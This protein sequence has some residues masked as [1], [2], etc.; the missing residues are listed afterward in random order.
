MSVSLKKVFA[1]DL[2]DDSDHLIYI[3]DWNV[4]LTQLLDTSSYLHD[5]YIK[6][7]E[8]V[9]EIMTE[10]ERTDV[11]RI[12]NADK[13]EYTW[14]K[15]QRKNRTL[16][17]LD[18]LLVSQNVISEINENK[19]TPSRK[20]NDHCPLTFTIVSDSMSPK[21]GFWRFYCNLLTD[22][23]YINNCKHVVRSTVMKYIDTENNT[24]PEYL[25]CE[26]SEV[27]LLPS[28]LKPSLL[29]DVI[30]FTVREATIKHIIE[31][32][33]NRDVHIKKLESERLRATNILASTAWKS[34]ELKESQTEIKYE[35]YNEL[36]ILDTIKSQTEARKWLAKVYLNAE[37]PAHQFCSMVA[38]QKGRVML[39]HLKG[40]GEK[41]KYKDNY[42]PWWRILQRPLHTRRYNGGGTLLL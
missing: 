37:T 40:K 14:A 11:W 13:F 27:T 18:F 2:I 25:N 12:F 7:R 8:F 17:W 23:L 39:A 22:P 10:K 4:T 20:L 26:T 3:G 24:N 19:I 15:N 35:I 9:K 16:A 28:K 21:P 41:T 29:L 36:D 42:V 38:R 6:N 34:E 32:K 31:K 5:N 33:S 1:D 30:L